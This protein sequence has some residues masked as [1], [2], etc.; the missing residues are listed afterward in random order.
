MDLQKIKAHFEEE[1][2]FQ[3]RIDLA[4]K[5]FTGKLITHNFKK[6][7]KLLG[8]YRRQ[9]KVVDIGCG[10][11]YL[12]HFLPSYIEV[13][14]VD[15]S[16]LA[17]D[18]ARKFRYDFLGVQ[19]DA[20]NLPFRDKSFDK[21]FSINLTPHLLDLE[22]FLKECFRIIRWNGLAVINFLNKY[23]LINIHYT[24]FNIRWGLYFRSNVQAP[25]PQ[26]NFRY[27][28]MRRL[29]EEAGFKTLGI[30]GW[31]ITFP[32][33]LGEKIP[34]VAYKLTDY[35]IQNEDSS[36]IKFLSNAIIFKL[37]KERV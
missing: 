16:P 15:L 35:M 21:L 6:I 8:P 14:G 37:K 26:N 30:Y 9:E 32:Y 1:E 23:G 25:S 11:G 27:S 17:L 24:V 31:G 7:V 28:E 12:I 29:V 10:F 34:K 5:G 20:H 33:F 19:T 22:K 36:P 3:K 18:L 13:Y 4:T 2:Q